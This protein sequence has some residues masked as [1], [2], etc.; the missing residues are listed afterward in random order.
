MKNELKS[1]SRLIGS[2]E[3][4]K[5]SLWPFCW[6]TLYNGIVIQALLQLELGLWT[7]WVIWIQVNPTSHRGRGGYGPNWSG[8]LSCMSFLGNWNWVYG[9]LGGFGYMLTLFPAGGGVD[10]ADLEI[11]LSFL[12][13]WLAY[14]KISSKNCTI[15]RE[16]MKNFRR[17]YI[18]ID[19]SYINSKKIMENWINYN[20]LQVYLTN[21][22]IFP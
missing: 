4:R 14:Q 12:A 22:R 19:L 13:A 7:S 16:K 17:K 21:C 20:F 9:P 18:K 6:L 10:M 1:Y 2:R 15:S 8:N 11:V 5:T 3:I